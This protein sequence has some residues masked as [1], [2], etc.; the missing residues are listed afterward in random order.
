M[1]IVQ[2]GHENPLLLKEAQ[3]KFLLISL[4]LSQKKNTNWVEQGRDAAG[5]GPAA[6]EKKIAPLIG[7]NYFITLKKKM[8]L[9]L[10]KNK[11]NIYL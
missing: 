3:K 6:L 9:N 4:R 7:I 8:Y 1:H 5:S 10:K 2:K 11:C